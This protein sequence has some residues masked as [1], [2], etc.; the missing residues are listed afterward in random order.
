ML[1]KFCF[2]MSILIFLFL[3][4]SGFYSF[5]RIAT[6]IF[7]SSSVVLFAPVIFE[8]ERAQMEEMQRSQQKQVMLTFFHKYIHLCW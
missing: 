7:F 1:L 6:W 4:V 5:G 3:F 2:Y 8:V